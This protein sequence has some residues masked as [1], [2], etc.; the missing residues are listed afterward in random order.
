MT[1]AVIPALTATPA[2]AQVTAL[3]QQLAFVFGHLFNG[4]HHSPL[5]TASVS[6]QK[7]TPNKLLS[8]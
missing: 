3:P 7:K 1:Q 6:S 5:R 8:V 2:A 4:F